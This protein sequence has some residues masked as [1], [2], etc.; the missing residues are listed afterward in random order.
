MLP[1]AI[2]FQALLCYRYLESPVQPFIAVIYYSGLVLECSRSTFSSPAAP[3]QS[4]TQ[5][6]CH[7]QHPCPCPCQVSGRE[8]PSA[9]SCVDGHWC[10]N[11]FPSSY[12]L[13]ENVA[14]P[15][16]DLGRLLSDYSPMWEMLWLYCAGYGAVDPAPSGLHI[17]LPTTCWP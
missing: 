12:L 10:W 14:S 3:L 6:L 11:G 2:H 5:C 9:S 8:A 15:W 13:A 17:H 7:P 16:R 1:E 4:C